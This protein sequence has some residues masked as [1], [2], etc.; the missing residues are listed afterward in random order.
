MKKKLSL[1]FV[2]TALCLMVLAGCGR[3]NNVQNESSSAG[4]T[5]EQTS[6]ENGVNQNTSTNGANGTEENLNNNGTTNGNGTNNA[7]EG[8]LEEIGTDIGNGIEDIGNGI[9][10]VG[11]NMNGTEGTINDN[12]NDV[13]N[14]RQS[15]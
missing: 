1:L 4:N 11:E 3:N 5:T 15:R 13:T 12:V 10:N 9:E 6:S 14:G 8:V 2:L 7:S